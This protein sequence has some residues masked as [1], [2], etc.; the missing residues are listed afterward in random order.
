[1]SLIK[2]NL[3]QALE[4]G[5]ISRESYDALITWKESHDTDSGSRFVQILGSFGAIATGLWVIL[6]IAANWDTIAPLY[7]TLVLTGT[8]LIAY[9]LGYYFSYKNTLYPKTWQALMFLGSMFYGASIMLLGQTYNLGGTF[10]EALLIWAVG[11]IPLAY[12]TRFSSIFLLALTLIYG[13]VFAEVSDNYDMTPFMVVNIFIILGYVSLLLSRINKNHGYDSFGR[14]ISWT[15]GVSLLGWLFAYTFQDF[16]KYGG[17]SW[18]TETDGKNLFWICIVSSFVAVLGYVWSNFIKN[19]RFWL[20]DGVILTSIGPIILLLFMTLF[21]E[22]AI[23]SENIIE[24]L[25][26]SVIMNIIYIGT[27]V[28]LIWSGIRKDIHSLVNMSMVWVAIYL[29]GRYLAFVFDSKMDG[30]WVFIGWGIICIL[31]TFLIEKI[32]RR[33]IKS[34]HS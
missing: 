27:L 4:E 1:M 32:R 14:I 2:I 7:K 30:A 28:F 23:L 19:K 22:T 16:W 18:N 26:R 33:I 15:G 5:V 9:I 11:V 3:E 17:N 34:M 29:F 10:A 21:I 20:Y 6:L 24:V 12:F 8:T 25:I 13:Y 31:L